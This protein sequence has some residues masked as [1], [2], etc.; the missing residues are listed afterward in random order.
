MKTGFRFG[1]PLAT[2]SL[3]GSNLDTPWPEREAGRAGY[4]NVV[5]P[6]VSLRLVS[7]G[8]VWGWTI[9]A[10]RRSSVIAKT[11]NRRELAVERAAKREAVEALN[12]VFKTTSVAIVAHYSGLTVAQMQ[13]LRM[14]LLHLGHGAA[15]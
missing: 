12:A 10:T 5:S 7:R 3:F 15:R 1:S 8:Q 6:G 11:A 4:W 13:K 14:Q 2:G 9:G